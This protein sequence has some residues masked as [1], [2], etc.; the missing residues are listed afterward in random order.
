MLGELARFFDEFRARFNAKHMA[1]ILR[2]EKQVVQNKAE[3]GLA[4]TMIG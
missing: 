3:I 1:Y 4:R 2:L